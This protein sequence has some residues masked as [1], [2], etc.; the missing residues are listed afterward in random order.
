MTKKAPSF[1]LRLQPTQARAIEDLGE[2]AAEANWESLIVCVAYATQAGVAQLVGE[3]R[4]QWNRFDTA[5]KLFVVGLDFGLTEP[6]AIR[7]LGTLKNASCHLYEA[8]RTLSARLCPQPRFHPK[9]YALGSSGS[10]SHSRSVSGITGSVNLTGAGLT[11]NVEAYTRFRTSRET[12][13]GRRWI[14]DLAVAE[15]LARSQPRATEPL[16]SEYEKLRRRVPALDI[17]RAEPTPGKY[18]PSHELQAPH[19]R[20]L[21]AARCLWTQT[22]RIVENRGVGHAGNQ[23]DLKRGARVFFG[24]RVPLQ[25]PI[26]TP[27]GTIDVVTG[28]GHEQCNLRYGNNGMDKVNL[29]IPGGANPPK[30]DYSFILWERIAGGSF[31]LHVRPDGKAWVR[32]S[33][34]EAALLTYAGGRR[35]WGFFNGAT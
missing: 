30:Y 25:A 3:L 8:R 9:L 31:K 22:L 6:A 27:L 14:Q 15:N 11:S 33:L 13:S 28:S 20:A 23:V 1:L 29:P 24:S 32:A 4:S 16:I 17:L 7:Y 35:S 12:A 34:E 21:Q 2:A 19:L 26:N 18:D 10:M 5:R